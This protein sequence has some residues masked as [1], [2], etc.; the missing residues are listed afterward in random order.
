MSSLGERR[1][2][3]LLL[4]GTLSLRSSTA[5]VPE[6]VPPNDTV[7]EG[8]NEDD[9][10]TAREEGPDRPVWNTRPGLISQRGLG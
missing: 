3:L 4:G 5:S 8:E 10:K 7:V 9:Q 6:S 1:L 2:S